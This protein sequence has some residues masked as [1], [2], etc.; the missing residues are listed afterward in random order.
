MASNEKL[1]QITENFSSENTEK[2]PWR[3]IAGTKLK[4][5]NRGL[6]WKCRELLWQT[7]VGVPGA[8]ACSLQFLN[9]VYILSKSVLTLV[10]LRGIA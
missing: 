10:F 8:A 5:M 7:M 3:A 6:V 1:L 9:R 4:Q 2:P